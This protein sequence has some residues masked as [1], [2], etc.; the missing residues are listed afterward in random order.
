MG[1]LKAATL[2][3]LAVAWMTLEVLG[4]KGRQVSQ[5][6]GFWHS[7]RVEAL[8]GGWGG[9]SGQHP[10]RGP[11]VGHSETGESVRY[12]HQVVNRKLDNGSE[13]KDLKVISVQKSS[14]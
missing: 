3:E 12:P 11:G 9:G 6:S 7:Q 2:T 14:I 10:G 5:D 8:M 1:G 4:G 13:N